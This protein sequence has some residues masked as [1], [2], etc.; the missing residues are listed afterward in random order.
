VRSVIGVAGQFSAVDSL[1]TGEEN[2]LLMGRML[3]LPAAERRPRLIFLDEPTTGLDPRSRRTMWQLIGDPVAEGVTILLTM[4]YLEEADKL[5]GRVAVLDR[6][7]IVAEGTPAE[8]KRR[9]PGAHIRLRFADAASLDAAALALREGTFQLLFVYILG[10]PIGHGLGDAARGSPYVDLLAPG[11][12]MMTVAAGCS[13][14]CC[15]RSRRRRQPS[16]SPT[17]W[18][19][20]AIR[21]S[22]PSASSTTRPS[23]GPLTTRACT[24]WPTE[25]SGG[26]PAGTAGSRAVRRRPPTLPSPGSSRRRPAHRRRPGTDSPR[27]PGSARLDRAG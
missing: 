3:H 6:G 5:A 19:R 10:G 1:L 7:R 9:I 18:T 16:G 14:S 8:L 20:S 22:A 2:L 27:S 21:S 25:P 24:R 13:G 15:S 17:N 26:S 11:V 4:Q 12:L 23:A